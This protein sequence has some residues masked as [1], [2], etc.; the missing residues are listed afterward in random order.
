MKTNVA[1]PTPGIP[2][3]VGRGWGPGACIAGGADA[4]PWTT[5]GEGRLWD[6]DGGQCHLRAASEPQQRPAR[7]LSFLSSLLNHIDKVKG[8]TSFNTAL[9]SIWCVLSLSLQCVASRTATAG[10]LCRHCGALALRR[11]VL[12][13]SFSGRSVTRVAGGGC[14]ARVCARRSEACAPPLR[15]PGK[16][17]GR[18]VSAA[19]PPRCLAGS[20]PL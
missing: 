7:D 17:Q 3:S 14:A 12:G 13:R 8:G 9:G 10:T 20:P 6:R 5:L 15:V 19:C 4:G 18:S 16:A 11:P 1:P 2:A